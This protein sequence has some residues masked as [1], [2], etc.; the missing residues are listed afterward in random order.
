MKGH[1]TRLEDGSGCQDDM[2]SPRK[3]VV[4]EKVCVRCIFHLGPATI[5]QALP[6]MDTC[7]PSPGSSPGLRR[8]ENCFTLLLPLSFS[9]FLLK[10]KLVGKKFEVKT[11]QCLRYCSP[12]KP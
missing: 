6:S 4:T 5:V 11:H 7:Y 8:R 9:F 10:V 2:D 12:S 1:P 3:L